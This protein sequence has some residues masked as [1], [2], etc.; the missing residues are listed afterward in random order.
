M[1]SRSLPVVIFTDGWLRPSDQ[2]HLCAGD[3]DAMAVCPRGLSKRMVL[4]RAPSR[5]CFHRRGLPWH[6][7][8][9]Q[10]WGEIDETGEFLK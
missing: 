2:F 9:G 3:G 10:Q 5:G 6:L 4:P 8:G 1:K 7:D